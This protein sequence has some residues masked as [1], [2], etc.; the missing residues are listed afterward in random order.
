MISMFIFSGYRKR[1]CFFTSRSLHTTLQGDW[2]SDVCSSDLRP[3]GLWYPSRHIYSRCC[4]GT[5]QGLPQRLRLCS[6]VQCAG[7]SVARS[8]ERRVGNAWQDTMD[9]KEVKDKVQMVP[10]TMGREKEKNMAL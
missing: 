3:H 1:Y 8:E 2:S 5:Q 10:F 4:P 9:E 7:G 6:A